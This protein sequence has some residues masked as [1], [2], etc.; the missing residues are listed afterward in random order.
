MRFLVIGGSGRTG[1]L[2]I[3]NILKRGHQVTALVRNPESL[4]EELG[5]DIVKGTPLNASDIRNAFSLAV[6]DVVIVTLSA[7]RATDSPF[8]API[9][10]P[11]MMADSNANVAQ[12]MKE[13]G[14]RK[15]V[16]LQAYGAGASWEKMP[17]AMR[18]LMSKSNMT[19]SYEDHNLA[20][21]EIR[22]SGLTFVLVRPSRLVETDIIEARE[23]PEDGKGVGLMGSASRI[24]VANFLVTAALETK[25]D[26]TAPVITN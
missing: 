7:L 12:I 6:L 4:G 11:R 9:S 19:F 1:K 8:A 25:W 5:L 23:W 21:K 24:S 10:P 17:C 14:V 16:V 18:L 2:L 20:E 26:G 3:D 15:I 22:D 13:F